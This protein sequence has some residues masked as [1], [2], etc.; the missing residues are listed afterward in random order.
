MTLRLGL[1]GGALLGLLSAAPAM[2]IPFTVDAFANSTSGTGVGLNTIS[3]TTGQNF[4]VTV[5]PTDL[6]NAGFLPRWS[7]ANG[8]TG[9]L[10]ATGTDDSGLAAGTKIG[11]AFPLWTQGG[12]TAPYGSL[13]GR[14]GAGNFFFIGANFAGIASGTGILQL[15]YFDS[16]NHDNSQFVTADVVAGEQA[17]SPVPLPGA[18]SLF[19][20]GLG[21]M[22]A[23]AWRRK[24]KAGSA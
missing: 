4:T 17:G 18:L 13:V 11:A 2:A 21:A 8:L 23:L 5:S 9:D 15:F 22:G 7:N 19:V 1:I 20:S 16:N 14:I 3:L 10:F 6:W 24:R 12:L